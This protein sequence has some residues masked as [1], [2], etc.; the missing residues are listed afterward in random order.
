MTIKNIILFVFVISLLPSCRKGYKIENGNVYYEYW[1]AGIG[2]GQGKRLVENAD[3]KTFQD[4][5]FDCDCSF[6]FGK[7]KNHLY[8]DGRPIK[9]ID[10][11]SFE[12]LG[13]YIFR[14]EN[15]AYFFGF[16]NN[17]NDC[18]IKGIP[19][20]KIKIIEYPWA[21]VDNVLI[22]GHDTL[23]L[24]DINDFIAID[25]NWGVTEKYVINDSD[26]VLGADVE[27]FKIINSYRG[28]DRD[29][30][31]EFGFIAKDQVQ[32]RDYKSF[33]F[34]KINFCKIGPTEF[35]KI[36]DDLEPFIEEQS[37]E[38]KIVRKL[39]SRDFTIHKTRQMK[40]GE[41]IIISV[42]LTSNSCNCYIDKIY[43]YDY[44][45][46]IELEKLFRVTERIHCRIIK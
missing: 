32:E 31:Y 19:P 45:R 22:H 33:D 34:D 2:I 14:D 15:A 23:S 6:E 27:T 46:P 11:N 16:Y 42:T 18:E 30:K 1:N 26:I 17:I 35:V 8:I 7:D 21:K 44:S 4:L 39:E 20:D 38:I 43:K 37:R 36:Y 40:L 25:E 13:N 3:A 41:S 24:E 5:S 9:D 12:F 10:Q 28:K 29:Y